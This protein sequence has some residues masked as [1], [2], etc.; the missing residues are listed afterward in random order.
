VTESGSLLGGNVSNATT[1]SAKRTTSNSFSVQNATIVVYL[2][3]EMG[4]HLTILAKALTVKLMAEKKYGVSAHLVFRHQLHP[5][6]VNGRNSIKACFPKLAHFNFS[7]A[8]T[9]A[10]DKLAREQDELLTKQGQWDPARIK[11]D[12]DRDDADAMKEALLYWKR[13]MQS[14]VDG[15][16]VPFLTVATSW[17]PPDIIDQYLDLIRDFFEFDKVA[18]CKTLPDPDES[19]FVS[20]SIALCYILAILVHACSHKLLL[21]VVV[22][23]ASSK[24]PSRNAKRGQE[25]GI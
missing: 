8:N 1:S 12:N 21:L 22:L 16:P 19:V 11:I 3:G 25:V 7:A 10:F 24:F 17:C 9:D 18:C 5:K 6:W 20:A 4:N 13:V 15:K 23:V 2:A 14:R